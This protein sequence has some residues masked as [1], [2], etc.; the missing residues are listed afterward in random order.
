VTIAAAFALAP[1][2]GLVAVPLGFAIG[3][4]AKAGLLAI[5]L[6]PRIRSLRPGETREELLGGEAG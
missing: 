5:A 1:S 6:V 4:I 3:M 2:I